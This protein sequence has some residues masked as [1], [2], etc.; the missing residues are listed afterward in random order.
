MKE[1]FLAQANII[2]I[3]TWIV[4][5]SFVL[6]RFK[7]RKAAIVFLI[8]GV[9]LF[10]AFSTAWLPRY[11]AYRL[12]IQYPPLKDLPKFS[13]AQKVYI[14]LLGS[15]YQTDKR[16]PST[17][18]LGL[19]A[20]SRFL[21]AMRL[22]RGISNST[23][24]CSA[25]GP[26]GEKTQAMTAS[27]AAIEMG[28][29]SS[30]ILALNTPSTTKEEAEDLAKSIGTNATVIVVTDAIHMPRAMKFFNEQGFAPIAAPVNFKALNG[31]TGVPFKWW[32]S[33]EN[34]YITNRVLHEYFASV[35]AAF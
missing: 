5:L 25:D 22:Y 21:E 11:L 9:V 17:A 19:V 18:K 27:A 12:E 6:Y 3:L 1:F 35:K 13:A 26:L 33:E 15:G 32:P 28:A 4:I 14:H 34:L 23:L 7:K 20:Q 16:L 2:S 30:R 31:S 8:F 29:D 24:V 10:Y